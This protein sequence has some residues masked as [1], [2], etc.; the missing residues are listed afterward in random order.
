MPCNVLYRILQMGKLSVKVLLLYLGDGTPVPVRGLELE[1]LNESGA[2]AADGERLAPWALTVVDR[3]EFFEGSVFTVRTASRE[4][5]YFKFL[6]AYQSPGYYLA[7]CPLVD[8]PTYYSA[9]AVTNEKWAAANAAHIR[10]RLK[11]NFAKHMSAVEVPSATDAQVGVILD[12]EY[13]GGTLL[14]SRSR[15][16]PFLQY[17]ETVPTPQRKCT[18]DGGSTTPSKKASLLEQFPFCRST[19]GNW[20]SSLRA[21][22]NPIG[23][24]QRLPSSHMTKIMLTRR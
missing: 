8:V 13:C 4:V 15:E 12:V 24:S 9:D 3:R 20:I 14:E 23:R 10:Y 7:L 22:R 19:S 18:S 17:L 21:V 2:I 16:T 11:G 1:Q 5:L 6:Y